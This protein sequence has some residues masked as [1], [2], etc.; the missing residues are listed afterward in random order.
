MGVKELSQ[1]LIYYKRRDVQEA[2]VKSAGDREV[3][4]RYGN[5]GFGKRPDILMYPNDVISLV[6]KGV[7]SFHISEEIWAD[8][9]QLTPG[10]RR[11]ELNELR[12]GWDLVLDIDFP[13]WV[14]SKLTAHFFIQALKKHGLSAITCK[15]SG[16]KGFHIGVPFQAFPQKIGNTLLKD[17]FPE[18]PQK[19]T[20]YLLDYISTKFVKTNK[21]KIVFDNKYEYSLPEL[22]KLLDIDVSTL[23]YRSRCNKCGKLRNRGYKSEYEYVCSK[24]ETRKRLLE[25]KKILICEKCSTIMNRYKHI[26]TKCECGSSDFEEILEFNPFSVIQIDTLLIS[27][28]HMFRSPY[29]LH[30]K[31]GLVSVVIDPG[32]VM[33]F[34]KEQAHPEK[35]TIREDRDFLKWKE[36]QEGEAKNLVFR[37]MEYKPKLSKEKKD[38]PELN[39]ETVDTALPVELFPPCIT[40]ILKGLTDGRKR[41]LFILLNFLSSVGWGYKQIEE[42]L[43]EWN[44]KNTEPLREVLIKGH[45][46]YHKQR[47]KKVFPPNCRSYYED[48]QVCIPDNLCN[49]IKNPVTYSKRKAFSL[50][51]PKKKRARLTEEQKEMRRKHRETLKNKK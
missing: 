22:A 2:I 26:K 24:C 41:S 27:S 17:W 44:M 4:F 34:E 48:F 39:F 9:M 21:D 42:L 11:G 37:A 13:N 33:N 45:I 50:N 20:Q 31:S 25:N 36:A 12:K 32:E 29:S 18:G 14:F 43:S 10:M 19:I 15:F 6:K 49:N 28:R 8:P 40:R 38:T 51:K 30:E 35:I 5:N 7:T 1:R 23:T 47:K 16:N 46:R 3:G